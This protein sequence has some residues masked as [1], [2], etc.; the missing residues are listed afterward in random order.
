M[1]LVRFTR[2]LARAVPCPPATV[3]GTTVGAALATYFVEHPRVRGYVL[4]DQGGVRKHVAVF[5]NGEPI[6]DRAKLSDLVTDTDE[7]DVL[8]ALSGG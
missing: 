3:A 7:I 5:V 6:A 2:Q 1:A 4:D 8:Q